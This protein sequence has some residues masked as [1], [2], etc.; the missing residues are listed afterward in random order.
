MRD[1]Y[2]VGKNLNCQ[3]EI[4]F[5]Q[6]RDGRPEIYDF[7]WEHAPALFKQLGEKNV[8]IRVQ[9]RTTREK[10]AS[11]VGMRQVE[12]DFLLRKLFED[13]RFTFKARMNITQPPTLE[14]DVPSK[15]LDHMLNAYNVF[16]DHFLPYIQMEGKD[17]VI[18]FSSAG[19]NKIKCQTRSTHKPKVSAFLSKNLSHSPKIQSIL[20]EKRTRESNQ[21]R[22]R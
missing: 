19:K 17:M 1:S 15:E 7:V 11:L 5:H 4:T 8:H 14:L 22:G 18:D 2:M 6:T 20:F 13:Q 10:W 3:M 9:P 12:L 16:I 21:K